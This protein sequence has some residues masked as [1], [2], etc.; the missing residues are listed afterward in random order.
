VRA[1]A[2]VCD[3]DALGD[4]HHGASEPQPHRD[5]ERN[6]V[7]AAHHSVAVAHADR[8]THDRSPDANSTRARALLRG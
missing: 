5:A 1:A 3:V 8:R 6:S 4:D 2:R 7:P